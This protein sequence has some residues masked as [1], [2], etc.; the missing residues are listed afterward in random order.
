MILA[1]HDESMSNGQKRQPKGIPVGGQYAENYHDEA[2]ALSVPLADQTPVDIDTKLADLYNAG[3]MIEDEIAR[4]NSALQ[5]HLSR[6]R[7]FYTREEDWNARAAGYEQ[8]I[9]EAERLLAENRAEAK[10]MED[11][12]TRRGGWTRAFL[13]TGSNGHVHRDMQCSTCFPTTRYYWV[14]DMSGQNEDEIVDAAGERACT[15]CYPSAPVD[16]LKRPSRIEDPKV[17]AEREA[18]A[19]EK[20][21]R[22]AERAVKGIT[23][24]VTGG[25]LIVRRSHV[26][27]ALTAE[28]E[29]VR[30]L[31]TVIYDSISPYN[32]RKHVDE[33]RED[34][35]VLLRALANKRGQSVEEVYEELREKAV[36]KFRKDSG[37]LLQERGLSEIP[38]PEF[39]PSWR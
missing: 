28:R 36:K 13:V 1:D 24:P 9:A 20:R 35:G 33:A 26:K 12:F 19:E 27:T 7:P 8:K 10:P 16:V 23:D 11:E 18:R 2:V 31:D 6:D 22:D 4:Q 5:S 17:V 14:T 3:V 37:W 21:K 32:N 39:D 29:A 38:S 15:V 25:D 34:I 30:L